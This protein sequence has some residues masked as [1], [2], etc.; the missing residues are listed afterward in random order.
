M[1]RNIYSFG[2]VDPEDKGHSKTPALRNVALTAILPNREV[3]CH[4]FKD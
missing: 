1:V 4:A 2:L 3:T